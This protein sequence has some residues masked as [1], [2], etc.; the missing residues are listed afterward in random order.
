[1]VKVSVIVPVY[2]TEI[3]LKQCID[4]LINQS[5]KDYEIIIINDCSKGNV[6]E[7]I[8]GYNDQKIRYI[9]NKVNKGIGYSRNLGIKKAKGDYVCFI[10]SDDYVEYDFIEKMYNKCSND[11]LDMCICDFSY[12]YENGNIKNEQ[13]CSFENTNLSSNQELLTKINL[14]P[15]NKLFNKDMIIKNKIK[16][17]ENLK[18]E[19]LP[20]VAIALQTSNKIGKVNEALNI[21]RVHENSETTTRDE[22]VFDIFK[23]LDIIRE[24]YK[25]KNNKYLDD[26]TVSIIFNYTIQ[27]RYQK[28][29]DIR[30]KFID[31][32]FYYLEKNNID[33]KNIKYNRSF[34]KR[35]VEKNKKL[36]KLY[37]FLYKKIKFRN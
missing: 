28:Y 33:Y 5:F 12:I 19:D 3:Y 4:S 7:I 20:F 1:M 11:N 31:Y 14:G 18:Y 16:F 8:S 27:Q 29:D 23:Q 26:L 34:L 35:I 9:K 25:D 37:C 32:A 10:D 15:C 2:N 24:F 30:N 6:D 22:R 21:F 13:I 36:T 17:S